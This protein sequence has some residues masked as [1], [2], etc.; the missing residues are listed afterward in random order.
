LES[1]PQSGVENA[2]AQV[3]VYCFSLAVAHMSWGQGEEELAILKIEKKVGQ[4]VCSP[5][6]WSI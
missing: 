6:I 5:W 4:G 1:S 2:I 3:A